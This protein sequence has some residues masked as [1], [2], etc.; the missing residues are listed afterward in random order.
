MSDTQDSLLYERWKAEPIIWYSRFE[1]YRLM[2]PKRSI[3]AV[4]KRECEKGTIPKGL[5]RAGKGLIKAVPS[6]WAAAAKKWQWRKRAEAWDETELEERRHKWQEQAESDRNLEH[7]TGDDLMKRANDM[8]SYALAHIEYPTDFRVITDVK[9]KRELLAQ[10]GELGIGENSNIN[11]CDI[12][13]VQTTTIK[14]IRWSMRD[15]AEFARVG[16]LL[17][18]QATGSP[19][20]YNQSELMLNAKNKK[21]QPSDLF[22]IET[23]HVVAAPVRKILEDENP[24]DKNST[25]DKKD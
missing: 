21:G 11:E 17:K 19:T 1:E 15:A 14:P 12:L 22:P 6:S 3:L 16:S 18:R 24:P 20:S 25:D 13:I 2:G 4:Y 7:K 8:L 9:Q 23:I 5:E 10:I